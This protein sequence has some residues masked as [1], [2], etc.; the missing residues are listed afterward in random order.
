MQKTSS[1]LTSEQGAGGGGCVEK[2]KG[3]I[4]GLYKRLATSSSWQKI[5]RKIVGEYEQAAFR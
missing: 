1:K 5:E 4:K 2:K 3:C